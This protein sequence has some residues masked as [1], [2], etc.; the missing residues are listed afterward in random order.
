ML[1]TLGTPDANIIYPK[2]SFIPAV[3]RSSARSLAPTSG[4]N[5]ERHQAFVKEDTTYILNQIHTDL[6][7]MNMLKLSQCIYQI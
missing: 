5:S 3:L 4:R 1:L 6:F 7:W 2:S